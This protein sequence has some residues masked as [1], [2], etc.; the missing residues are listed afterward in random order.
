MEVVAT[1]KRLAIP[2]KGALLSTRFLACFANV[3]G[4]I[5]SIIEESFNTCFGGVLMSIMDSY[6]AV[7][8]RSAKDSYY[9]L[10]TGLVAYMVF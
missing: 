2:P 7:I 10:H 6:C 1:S 8:A 5:F 9:A 4:L 3:V